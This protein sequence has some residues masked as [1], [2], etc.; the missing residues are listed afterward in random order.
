MEP[1]HQRYLTTPTYF[2]PTPRKPTVPSGKVP[3][4][5][6]NNAIF[7]DNNAEQKALIQ[8]TPAT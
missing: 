1:D 2:Y 3:W 5:I 6:M 7:I 4:Y 8:L